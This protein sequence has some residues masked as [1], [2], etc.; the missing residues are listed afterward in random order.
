MNKVYR[1]CITFVLAFILLTTTI[2]ST[3]CPSEAGISKAAKTSLRLSSLTRDAIAATKMAYENH[4]ISLDTKDKMAIQLD[5]IIAGGETF[6]AAVKKANDEY[7][8]SG[9]VNTSALGLLNS[10][11]TSEVTTPFL[12]FLQL[13]GAVSAEKAPYLWA[14]I[15]AFRAALLLIG[16]FVSQ[17]SIKQI[18]DAYSV[19]VLRSQL[20]YGGV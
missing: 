19:A 6:N 7:K 10:L 20:A 5:K 13:L 15:N 11:L 3:G 4:L 12:A 1:L 8:A 14:A 17:N 9:Q 2:V 18:N 16:S